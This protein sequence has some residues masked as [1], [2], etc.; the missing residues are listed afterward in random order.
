MS[1]DA[2]IFLARLAK[3]SRTKRQQ[4]KTAN[5]RGMLRS[6]LSSARSELDSV[7]QT[8]RWILYQ[9]CTVTHHE[10]MSFGQTPGW[11]DCWKP[12]SHAGYDCRFRGKQRVDYGNMEYACILQFLYLQD[13]Y[14]KTCID[15]LASY[16]PSLLP[17]SWP[18]SPHGVEM[19][20]DVIEVC[21]AALRGNPWCRMDV[22]VKQQNKTLPVLFQQ[23]LSLCQLVQLIDAAFERGYIKR[24]G[25]KVIKLTKDE[26]F[27]EDGLI[28][29]WL[30]PPA[31]HKHG[32]VLHALLNSCQT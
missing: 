32:Y 3:H 19:Q 7:V 21:L 13:T 16:W 9:M 25:E 4:M 6:K 18:L 8:F 24:T 29:S 15:Y 23:V 31:Y 11:N 17:V 10:F 1:D 2:E 5:T 12:T 30:I 20:G 22:E 28:A 26:D 14:C 27:C